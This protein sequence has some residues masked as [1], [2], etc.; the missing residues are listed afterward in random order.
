VGRA[1]RDDVP[2]GLGFETWLERGEEVGELNLADLAVSGWPRVLFEAESSFLDEVGT[3]APEPFA[4]AA[5]AFFRGFGDLARPFPP[6]DVDLGVWR[7]WSEPIWARFTDPASEAA[8]VTLAESML[9][10]FRDYVAR[11]PERPIGNGFYMWFDLIESRMNASAPP[12]R[13]AYL[14]TLEAILD[15]EDE[16]CQACALHGLGHLDHPERPHVV[17]RYIRRHANKDLNLDW[18]RQCRDGTVM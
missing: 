18:L 8:E 17:D 15:L 6:E 2:D 1:D 5:S 13:D 12:V 11:L 10:P 9:F 16:A 3:G 14:R 4:Q 7:L